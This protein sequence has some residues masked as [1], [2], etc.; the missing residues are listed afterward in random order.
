M[1]LE[2]FSDFYEKDEDILPPLNFDKCG[3]LQGIDVV[4]QEPLADLIFA[5]QKIYLKVASKESAAID[6]LA[7][8]LESLCTR[9]SQTDLEHLSAVSCGVFEMSMDEIIYKSLIT[10]S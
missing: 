7:Q 10:Y 1:L 3:S 8:L 6:K 2:H 9:M 5:L 4:L